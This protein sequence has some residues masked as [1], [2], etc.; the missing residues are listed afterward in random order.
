MTGRA[1]IVEYIDDE[2]IFDERD[3]D[4]VKRVLQASHE[5]LQECINCG[6]SVTGEHGIG[7]EKIS[8]MDRLFSP[9]DLNVMR[10]IRDCF[11]PTGRCSPGKM[12]PTSAGCGN[13]SLI[14]QKPGRRAA[15]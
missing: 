2:V 15:M 11:N 5:I 12:L 4:Q 6:G 14:K 1:P 7:V 9:E 10:L 13:E 8:F 3:A